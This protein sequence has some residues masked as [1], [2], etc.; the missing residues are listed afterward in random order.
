MGYL[1]SR[2][3]LESSLKTQDEIAKNSDL[4]PTLVSNLVASLSHDQNF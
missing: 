4:E 1:W 3:L 2:Y